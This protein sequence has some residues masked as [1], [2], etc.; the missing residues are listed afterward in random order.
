VISSSLHIDDQ[1]TIQD[2]TATTHE[3]PG[4]QHIMLYDPISDLIAILPSD[5]CMTSTHSPSSSASS[6][7]TSSDD[8]VAFASNMSADPEGKLRSLPTI[9]D[10]CS[11]GIAH[12]GAIIGYSADAKLCRLED[13]DPDFECP[14]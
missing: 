12:L 7:G 4:S 3:N 1:Q 8:P 2:I 14:D 10:P 5:P 11:G 13:D 6:T 9:L